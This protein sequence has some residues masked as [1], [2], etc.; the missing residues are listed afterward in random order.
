MKFPTQPNQTERSFPTAPNSFPT[1]PTTN[2]PAP[3]TTQPNQTERNFPTAP[4]N[5]PGVPTSN[6][7]NVPSTN[8]SPAV[9][10]NLSNLPSVPNFQPSNNHPSNGHSQPLKNQS[11][12]ASNGN[13]FPSVPGPLNNNGAGH[14]PAALNNQ[15]PVLSPQ[16]QA[17]VM[18]SLPEPQRPQNSVSPYPAKPSGMVANSYVPTDDEILEA[19]QH[20]KQALSA[21]QFEDLN[22]AIRNLKLSYALLLG[23][24][25]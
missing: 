15:V 12:P 21:L 6:F 11:N 16:T 23:E 20:V 9:P 10:T 5:F 14:N 24:T 19:Q 2:F 17:S 1:V 18:S 13:N 8:N 4:N 3:P 22:S 25:K 7:H